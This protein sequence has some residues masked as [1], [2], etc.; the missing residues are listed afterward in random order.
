MSLA[1]SGRI[2]LCGDARQAPRASE[3]APRE[4][5]EPVPGRDPGARTRQRKIGPQI[6]VSEF[7]PILRWSLAAKNG[8]VACHWLA[9]RLAVLVCAFKSPHLALLSRLPFLTPNSLDI[10]S[11]SEY[12]PSGLLASIPYAVF[13][14]VAPL[15]II[16]SSSVTS[17]RLIHRCRKIYGPLI[18]QAQADL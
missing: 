14:T 12:Y 15:S 10:L 13:P 6:A 4:P 17:A 8:I 1:A 18:A 16:I 11:G 9:R 5:G 2:Q 3:R 7:G